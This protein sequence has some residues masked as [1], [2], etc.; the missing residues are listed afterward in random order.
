MG[1]LFA[2]FLLTIWLEDPMSA[3]A[4]PA[5]GILLLVVVTMLA[6]SIVHTLAGF[7]GISGASFDECNTS[8][9]RYYNVGV[10]SALC[11]GLTLFV[12]LFITMDHL[13]RALIFSVLSTSLLLSWP[14]VVRRLYAERNFDVVLAGADAPTFQRAPDAG[15][16]ALGWTLIAVALF[17]L[18]Q[19]LG[20]ALFAQPLS[21]DGL[22]LLALVAGGE[23]TDI[24]VRS[25]WW[26]VG[27]SGLQLW[28]G[29]ELVRMSERHKLAAVLYGVLTS[30]IVV[31]VLWPAADSL[32][33]LL[34]GALD[35]SSAF[36]GRVFTGAVG[37]HLVFA[38]ATLVL[39]NRVTVPTAVVHRRRKQSS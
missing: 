3:F 9:S 36:L 34:A 32:G 16:I 33:V 14:N 12:V 6:R 8:A 11:I 22:R 24:V 30:G 37:L 5:M 1:T 4:S 27:V 29:I 15:L 13:G 39:V 26:S 17:G 38:L 23:G 2:G 20:E 10:V 7:K 31:Y 21:D 18:G 19:G 28:A 25:P 35:D